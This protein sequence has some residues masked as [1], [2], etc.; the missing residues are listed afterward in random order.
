L[1]TYAGLEPGDKILEVGSGTGNATDLIAGHGFAITCLE[2]GRNLAALAA[3]KYHDDPDIKFDH[4]RFED[5][6]APHTEF[7]ALIS[8]QAYHWVPEE[9]RMRKAAEVLKPGGHIAIIYN[10]PF[11]QNSS[12]RIEMDRVYQH[13][14]PEISRGKWDTEAQIQAITDEIR[15]SGYFLEPH[16]ELIPWSRRMTTPAYIGLLNTY[17]DHMRLPDDKKERLMDGIAQ[18]IEDHGGEIEQDYVAVMHIAQK[19]E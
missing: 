14:S 12:E 6:I 18:V 17:S 5:W 16:V 15:D 7:A 19:R 2:P 13:C 10:K 3:K 11:P 4:G 8:A 1:I 9:V